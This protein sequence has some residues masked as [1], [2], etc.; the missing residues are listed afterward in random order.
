[1]SKRKGL[2]KKVRFEIFK[3]D[4]FRCKY[5]GQ[6]T[7]NGSILNVDH[8]IPV[9]HGGTNDFENLITS[10]FDCNIG[11]SDN[12]LNVSKIISKDFI[13]KE[14]FDDYKEQV[15]CFFDFVNSKEKTIE[16]MTDTILSQL[17]NIDT[18]F[19]KNHRQSVRNFIKKINYADLLDYSAQT[20]A[21]LFNRSIYSKFKYFCGICHNI[22]KD[23]NEAYNGKN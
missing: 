15:K 2:S 20:N 4:D 3:R 22:I 10:C 9:S 1:M 7:A 6:S 23:K 17:G 8:V 14:N 12:F 11:K 16:K 19:D 5:C 21:K 13:S 18:D